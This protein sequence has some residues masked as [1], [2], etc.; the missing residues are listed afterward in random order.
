MKD[1]KKVAPHLRKIRR[2]M[3]R[4][5][6]NEKVR[7][8]TLEGQHL[9]KRIRSIPHRTSKEIHTLVHIILMRYGTFSFS[10]MLTSH[11]VLLDQ[12]SHF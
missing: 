4:V 6:K 8:N 2:S 1:I 7:K 10:Q 11:F 3:S 12:L 5:K 9:R